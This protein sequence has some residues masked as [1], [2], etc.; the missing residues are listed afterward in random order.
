MIAHRNGNTEKQFF[1]KIKF[2]TNN[3][4]FTIYQKNVFLNK[5]K[6]KDKGKTNQNAS[7]ELF[8]MNVFNA[9]SAIKQVLS[10][11]KVFCKISQNV[12]DG[13]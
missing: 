3:I 6:Q 4:Y 8:G 9:V 10:N 1:I 7:S 12:F 2:S 13:Q 11:Y 5:S